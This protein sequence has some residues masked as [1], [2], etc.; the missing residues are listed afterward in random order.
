METPQP[1]PLPP[2]PPSISSPLRVPISL[3]PAKGK[4]QKAKS[5]MFKR[6][7]TAFRSLPIMPA[8]A[9]K[10]PA[11]LHGTLVTDHSHIHGGTK[12]TGTLFGYRKAR[13]N[14]AFQD[15]PRSVPLL[16]LELAIPTGKL[17]Q[18]MEMGVIRIALECEKN[19]N[20]KTRIIDE[21]MWT[22]FYNGKKIGYGAKREPT[23]DDLNVMQLL[24]VVSAGAGVLPNP[25]SGPHDGELSYM[26]AYFDRVTGSKDSESYYMTMPEGSNSGPELSVFFVRV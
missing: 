2:P 3:Q 14:L 26:R 6:F 11:A 20:E 21:P 8:P 1:V 12:I 17:L 13:V 9:C 19:P 22:L 7:R 18:G 23:D 5:K 25:M 16:L 10:I 24:H 4:K 15:N